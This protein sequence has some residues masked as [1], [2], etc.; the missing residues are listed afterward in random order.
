M[1]IVDMINMNI[2]IIDIIIDIIIKP[3]IIDTIISARSL[4][5]FKK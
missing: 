3:I 2:I 1:M 4:T 5:A